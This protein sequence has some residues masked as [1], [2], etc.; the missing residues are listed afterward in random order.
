M[1]SINFILLNLLI[2]L[3][4]SF[5]IYNRN[6]QLPNFR[7]NVIEN[8]FELLKSIGISFLIVIPLIF[9]QIYFKKNLSKY[10]ITSA[11]KI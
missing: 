2:I 10:G 7:N 3:V 1:I 11:I 8:K 9:F 4:I 6:R 5:L